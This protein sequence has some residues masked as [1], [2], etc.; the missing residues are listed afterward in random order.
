MVAEVL[1]LRELHPVVVHE[2]KNIQRVYQLFAAPGAPSTKLGQ[3]VHLALNYIGK[4]DKFIHNMNLETS[5]QNIFW[6]LAVRLVDN[7]QFLFL[8]SSIHW[9]RIQTVLNSI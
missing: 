4:F 3:R 1:R 7:G 5:K 9:Q 2:N 8:A 6:H